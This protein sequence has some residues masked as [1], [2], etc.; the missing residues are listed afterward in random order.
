MNI[1][2]AFG[3]VIK[4]HRKLNDLSQE[5]LAFQCDLD[6]TYI[7]LLERAKRQPSLTTIFKIANQLHIR[8]HEL[9]KEVEG[10]LIN[11][12]NEK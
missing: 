7:G 12:E 1:A 3:K 10:L 5:Q 9:L 6:R 4:K 8:P 11:T 2:E